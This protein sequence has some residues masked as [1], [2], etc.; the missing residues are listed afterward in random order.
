MKTWL[1]W[2]VVGLL[3]VG[4]SARG[5]DE[6]SK[7]PTASS[8]PTHRYYAV[9]KGIKGKGE[10]M[11]GIFEVRG[12]WT[13]RGG[14]KKIEGKTVEV[15]V[16]GEFDE[17]QWREEGVKGGWLLITP[18]GAE[19]R[20]DPSGMKRGYPHPRFWLQSLRAMGKSFDAIVSDVTPTDEGA[21]VALTL[22]SERTGREEEENGTRKKTTK[23]KGV[24]RKE[25][26]T[27]AWDKARGPAPVAK[28]QEVGALVGESGEV[29]QITYD[30]SPRFWRKAADGKIEIAFNPTVDSKKPVAGLLLLKPTGLAQGSTFAH[31]LPRFGVFLY[32]EDAG[33]PSLD[34]APLPNDKVG[35]PLLNV[36]DLRIRPGHDGWKRAKHSEEGYWD[37]CPEVPEHQETS[38]A[39]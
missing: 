10:S 3:F 2:L 9:F 14:L 11:Q 38:G 8:D 23:K 36:P 34:S 5:K 24:V 28:G 17:Q 21:K 37:D 33:S 26:V 35:I 15:P 20:G 30:A 27:I 12:E 16:A 22:L 4:G 25:P 19:L 13:L 1:R 6:A 39:G 32:E 7:K 31:W 18:E 29:L